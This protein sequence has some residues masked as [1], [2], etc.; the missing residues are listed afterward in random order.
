MKQEIDDQIFG[1]Y[2]LFSLVYIAFLINF[3]RK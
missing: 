2:L 1:I 3:A